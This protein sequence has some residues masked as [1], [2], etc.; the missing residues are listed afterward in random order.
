MSFSLSLLTRRL[1][2]CAWLIFASF[3]LLALESAT[4]AFAADASATWKA[5]WE[6]IVESAKKEGQIS[7]YGSDTFEL[8]LKSA[9]QKKYP[10]IKI[11][12]VG[13]RAPVVGPKLITERRAGKYLADV[14]L[15][16]PGLPT[17]SCTKIMR[18]IRLDRC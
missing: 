1:M 6:K 5:T 15:T 12:F 11:G 2:Q 13:G 18:W 17:G 4:P 9:F 16:G 8:L 3:G 10:E 14:M 7:V